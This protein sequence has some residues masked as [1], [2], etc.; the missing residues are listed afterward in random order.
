[1]EYKHSKLTRSIIGSAIEVH[2]ELGPGLP[3]KLYQNA[4]LLDLAEK[5]HTV[6]CEQ[7]IDVYFKGQFIG[8]FRLDIIVDNTVIVELKAVTGDMPK[9]FHSQIITYLKTSKKEVG[10]LI[11]FGN[12]SIEVKRFANYS[13]Y[14]SV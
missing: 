6:K 1:M 2:K 13:D 14:H 9:I 4:L 11:N 10:L 3:E 8:T 5:G 12:P 7:E